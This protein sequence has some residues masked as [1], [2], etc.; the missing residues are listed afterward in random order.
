MRTNDIVKFNH[1][2]LSAIQAPKDISDME[3][4]IV[5]VVRQIK[6]KL[7]YVKVLW[8]GESEVKG[9][10]SSNLAVVRSGLLMDGTE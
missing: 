1:K 9:C 3:G 6:P 8:N 2:Y 7:F 10:L 5:E 4:R